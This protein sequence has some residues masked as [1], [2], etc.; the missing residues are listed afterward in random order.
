M[1]IRDWYIHVEYSEHHSILQQEMRRWESDKNE[2]AITSWK[3]NCFEGV[4]LMD[5]WFAKGFRCGLWGT[6]CV[7]CSTGLRN[8]MKR[9]CDPLM[10]TFSVPAPSIYRHS[11]RRPSAPR[12][13]IRPSCDSHV[14][15][16]FTDAINHPVAA[17]D[18][19][20]HHNVTWS[21]VG[22]V[23]LNFF[24]FQCPNCSNGGDIKRDSLDLTWSQCFLNFLP[25]TQA[26]SCSWI[27]K[28]SFLIVLEV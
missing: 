16:T 20:L 11:C 25:F 12:S 2:S 1:S 8:L 22:K 28:W 27:R 17:R 26:F 10:N 24:G 18:R 15:L 14:E 7:T 23:Q 9:L 4:N 13:S 6:F 19:D 21:N 5:P 3:Y